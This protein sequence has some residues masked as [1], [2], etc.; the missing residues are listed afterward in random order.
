MDAFYASVEVLDNP[1]LR[2]KPFGVSA[3]KLL[4]DYVLLILFRF[5][6]GWPLTWCLNY[7]LV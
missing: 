5:A 3:H 4:S 6:L 2:G 1:S 7:C